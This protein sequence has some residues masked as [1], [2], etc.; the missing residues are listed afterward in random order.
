MGHSQIERIILDALQMV[1]LTREDNKQL[2]VSAD[3]PLFGNGGQLDSMGLVT[4]I[5]DIEE[6]LADAGYNVTLTS[7]Q[8]MSRAQSPFKDVPSLVAF[9]EHHLA[10]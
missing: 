3:A 6:A 5:I 10:N 4:L 2:A 1:N 8:A 9:I 7:E